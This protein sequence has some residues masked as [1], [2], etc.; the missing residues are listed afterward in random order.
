MD[1]MDTKLSNN[2][3]ALCD[4]AKEM[5]ASE[6]AIIKASNVVVDDR[7]ILKCLVP[8]C[9]NYGTNL[10]CP[11]N[12]ISVDDFRQALKAYHKA[13][14]IKV[15][16]SKERPKELSDGNNISEIWQAAKS[17]N[18]Q[19]VTT[20]LAEYIK[21]LRSGHKQMY[22]ILSQL[23]SIGLRQ[24][25]NFVAGFSAGGCSLCDQCVGPNSELSCRYPFQARPSMEGVGIDVVSTCNNAGMDLEFN[26]QH[27]SWIGLVLV[28]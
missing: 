12:I 26:K 17:L 7:V 3:R 2:L 20:S 6:V 9:A 11:P 5:G 19:S 23:E 24:G 27:N 16:A 21:T 28:D 1:L 25:Y 10:M 18:K 14:L 15:V 4:K 8:R 22:R 13:V